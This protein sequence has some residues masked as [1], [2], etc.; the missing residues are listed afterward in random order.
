M[1]TSRQDILHTK[2][3]CQTSAQFLAY[4]QNHENMIRRYRCRNARQKD[5]YFY[6]SLTE[7]PHGKRAVYIKIDIGALPFS[8]EGITV[9][10]SMQILLYS[11]I[12]IIKPDAR[13]HAVCYRPDAA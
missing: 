7:I 9:R 10:R 2:I 3:N 12:D 6:A 13:Q 11:V 4:V 8:E 5:I 1:N